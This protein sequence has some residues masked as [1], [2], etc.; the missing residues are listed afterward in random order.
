MH[1]NASVCII[2]FM[3]ACA[4]NETTLVS[5]TNQFEHDW[6]LA[7]ETLSWS[8]VY[9]Q[10]AQVDTLWIQ[11]LSSCPSFPSFKCFWDQFLFSSTLSPSCLL[12]AYSPPMLLTSLDHLSAF[13]SDLLPFVQLVRSIAPF[14]TLRYIFK[15]PSSMYLCISKSFAPFLSNS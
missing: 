6:W 2:S 11:F 7:C 5:L 15:Q 13:L 8:I 9:F 14:I 10:M 4:T 1:L 3:K 12:L